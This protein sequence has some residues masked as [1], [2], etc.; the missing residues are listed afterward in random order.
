M[1]R[2]F[3]NSQLTLAVQLPS[4]ETFDSFTSGVEQTCVEQIKTFINAAADT[5]NSPSLYL[6]GAHGVGKSHLLHAACSYAQHYG[7]SSCCMSFSQ[8][9]ELSLEVLEGIEQFDLVCLD[10]IQLIAGDVNWQQA[11]FDLY[12]RVNEQG[13]KIIISGIDAVGQLNLTLPDLVSRLSWGQ[14]AQLKTLTDDEKITALVL[15]A[16]QRGMEMPVE[17]GKYLINHLARDMASLMVCLNK[18]DSASIREQRKLTVP[19]IKQIL[20]NE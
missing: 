18:L 12:N 7:Q 17:V 20:I 16:K 2:K 10:D 8:L 14:T 9:K 5:L 6:F 4:D 1:T 15:H 11:V 19:F 3:S 13:H